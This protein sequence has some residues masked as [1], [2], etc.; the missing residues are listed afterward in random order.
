MAVT[1]EDYVEDIFH[2]LEHSNLFIFRDETNPPICGDVEERT[3]TNLPE[4]AASSARMVNR[5]C[6]R[7]TLNLQK[8]KE[9]IGLANKGVTKRSG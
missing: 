6:S 9:F 4:F 3:S 8:R 2:E 1:G 7:L 5:L